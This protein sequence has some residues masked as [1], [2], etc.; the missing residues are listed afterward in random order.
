[1]WFTADGNFVETIESILS[2]YI[3][4]MFLSQGRRLSSKLERL[5][6]NVIIVHNHR[7]DINL[8]HFGI[9]IENIYIRCA[10]K[11]FIG[12][13]CAHQQKQLR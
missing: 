11:W 5:D 13:V 9:L 6:N 4:S 7:Y 10:R 12:D 1:M 2:S 8:R 3:F